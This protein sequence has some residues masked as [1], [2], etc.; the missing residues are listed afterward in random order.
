MIKVDN[1]L[2]IYSS[3]VLPCKS[4]SISAGGHG[5]GKSRRS[6]NNISSTPLSISPFAFSIPCLL[7]LIFISQCIGS[8][9]STIRLISIFCIHFSSVQLLSRVLL[10]ATP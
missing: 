5:Q 1:H 3:P 4:I 8:A 7:S 10:F 6:Q 9:V 2:P